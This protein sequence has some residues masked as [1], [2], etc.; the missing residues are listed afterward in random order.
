MKKALGVIIGIV[1]I[2]WIGLKL[3]NRVESKSILSSQI[4]FEIYLDD[5]LNVNEYFELTKDTFNIQEHKVLCILP[6]EISGFK[7]SKAL[8]QNDLSNINCEAKFEEGKFI[9]YEPYEIKGKDFNFII[10]NR[11]A[12]VT[13]LDAENLNS[14]LGRKLILA[15]KKLRYNYKK[16][17][18]NRLVVSENGLNEYCK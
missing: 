5:N 17:K 11:N 14:S 4:I 16:G 1:A 9:K 18:I 2:I 10:V 7:P 3:F 15:K 6:V 8:V 13:I 12:N